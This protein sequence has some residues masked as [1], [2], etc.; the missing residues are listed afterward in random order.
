MK[1]RRRCRP[2]GPVNTWRKAPPSNQLSICYGLNAVGRMEFR[3]QI[4][5]IFSFA[6]PAASIRDSIPNPHF[7]R[8]QNWSA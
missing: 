5:L 7:A 3:L 2:V 8:V 6:F 4:R 1:I